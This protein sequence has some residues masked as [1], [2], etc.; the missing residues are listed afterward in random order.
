MLSPSDTALRG[1][2]RLTGCPNQQWGGGGLISR[3]GDL[4]PDAGNAVDRIEAASKSAPS[5]RTRPFCFRAR[6][7]NEYVIMRQAIAPEVI[8]RAAEKHPQP[9]YDGKIEGLQFECRAARS[10]AITRFPGTR[11]IRR[12]DTSLGLGHF[13]DLP[14]DLEVW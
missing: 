1:K 11:P 2:V 4:W 13:Y 5:R 14:L 8:T 6:V 12:L 3:L 7:K 10:G 9:V